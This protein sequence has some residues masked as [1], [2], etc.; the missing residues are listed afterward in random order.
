M[1]HIEEKT[2]CC[3]CRGCEYA[4][5]YGALKMR[6]DGMG[7]LYPEIDLEKCTGCNLCVRVCAFKGKSIEGEGKPLRAYALKHPDEREIERSQS[8]AAF[9]LLS[10]YILSLGGVV[11]GAAFGDGLYVIHK[12]GTDT[13]TRDEFRGSKYVQ[14][15]MRNVYGMINDDLKKGRTVLFSGTPCQTAAIRR[16]FGKSGGDRLVLVDLVCHGVASPAIWR[17]YICYLERKHRATIVDAKFRDKKFGW[18]SHRESYAFSDGRTVYPRFLV[19]ARMFMRPSCGGCKYSSLTRSSDI[20]IG[21]FWGVERVFPDF[22]TNN[23]G[24]SLM[25]CNTEKGLRLFENVRQHVL[26][27]KVSDLKDVLQP[28]L[29]EGTRLPDGHAAF[30]DYYGANGFRRT[31]THF[32]YLGVRASVLHFLHRARRKMR[33]LG[34]INKQ[35]Q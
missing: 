12:R 19:Y 5:R 35:I 10:D 6:P 26:C 22:E 9:P 21:D 30:A 11:Y 34:I 18:H 16:I 1:I 2:E 24:C 4:C 17:D 20:T 29:K 8:G 31:M 25:L 32:G 7:F 3:G 15:D 33:S 28:N 14:S 23:R 13:E 27:R